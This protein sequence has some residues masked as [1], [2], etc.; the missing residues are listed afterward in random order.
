MD[1]AIR[2]VAKVPPRRSD[3]TKVAR[4]TAKKE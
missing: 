2:L 1:E 3:E 4:T